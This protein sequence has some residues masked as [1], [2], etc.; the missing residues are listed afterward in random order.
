MVYKC[1]TTFIIARLTPQAVP[2]EMTAIVIIVR[3]QTSNVRNE[4][5]EPA[6]GE[7]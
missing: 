7:E 6:S 3:G 4:L 5:S 2:Y 1:V